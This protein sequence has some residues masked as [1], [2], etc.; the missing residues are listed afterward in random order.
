MDKV[1][2]EYL[3]KESKLWLVNTVSSLILF[4]WFL[5]VAGA[6]AYVVAWAFVD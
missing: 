4:C 2:K 6:F 1:T 3:K 5:L